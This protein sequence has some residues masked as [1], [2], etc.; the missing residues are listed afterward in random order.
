MEEERTHPTMTSHLLRGVVRYQSSKSVPIVVLSTLPAMW[1]ESN[2]GFAWAW[3]AP[4][5]ERKIR[6][7]A[8]RRSPLCILHVDWSFRRSAEREETSDETIRSRPIGA[9]PTTGKVRASRNHI[10]HSIY[11][12]VC[13]CSTYRCTRAAHYRRRKAV[14]HKTTHGDDKI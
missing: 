14:C 8:G 11:L 9:L 12:L 7:L 2:E 1:M 6:N 5:Y 10:S 13:C 3:T 4:P